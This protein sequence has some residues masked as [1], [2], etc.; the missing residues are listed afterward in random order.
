MNYYHLQ[1][2]TDEPTETEINN[3]KR[4]ILFE[5]LPNDLCLSMAQALTSIKRPS[6][7]KRYADPAIGHL[8]LNKM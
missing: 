8:L 2:R 4:F 5:L 3:L 7:L 1:A 6:L